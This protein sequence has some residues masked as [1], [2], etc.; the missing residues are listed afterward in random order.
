MAGTVLGSV[1]AQHFFA[2]HP[3]AHQLFGDNEH[4]PSDRDNQTSADADQGLGTDS[5]NLADASDFDT[6]IA[7]GVDS[8][9]V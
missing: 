8:W 2:N 1:V 3:E 5:D 9:D 7:S 6:D 4:V